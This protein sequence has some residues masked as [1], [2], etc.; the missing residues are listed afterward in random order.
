MDDTKTFD[1]W[2]AVRWPNTL[3]AIY[4]YRG[5]TLP[6][7]GEVIDVSKSFFWPGDDSAPRTARARVVRINKKDDYPIR[8]KQFH[9]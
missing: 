5:E 7:V 9:G 2:L 3:E 8:A 1:V 4:T 6:A